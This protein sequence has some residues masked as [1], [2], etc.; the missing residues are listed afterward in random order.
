MNYQNW[1]KDVRKGQKESQ[2]SIFFVEL[3]NLAPE[4]LIRLKSQKNEL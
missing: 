3:N 4:K 2:I 1:I